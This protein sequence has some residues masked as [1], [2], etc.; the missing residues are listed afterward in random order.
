[1]TSVLNDTETIED[2]Q[3]NGLQLIQKKRGFRFGM[4]SVLLSDFADI[5]PGDT[6]ADIG[7]GNGILIFLL[8]G[9]NKGQKYYAIDIQPEATELVRR[10]AV[11]NHMENRISVINSDVLFAAQHIGPCSV[12]AA[13]CNPPYGRP[14]AALGSPVEAKSIARKQ[15]NDT[16]DHMLKGAYLI[17]K[18][19]GRLFLVYPASQMLFL[20]ESLQKHHLEPKRF[21]MVYPYIH[22]PANLVLVEA[23]KDAKPTLHP[24]P[25]LTVY[26][27]DGSLTN[28]L[29]SVYHIT[30]QTES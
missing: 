5:R 19:K 11:L 29:K 26:N 12:D 20:M 22:K 18:G 6:V 4:D 21:Q 13:V 9:R 16:L 24:M 15:E 17:L 1:M 8:S 2:L 28:D 30:E 7:T 25:A 10:N 14:E 3:L 23:V 27:P